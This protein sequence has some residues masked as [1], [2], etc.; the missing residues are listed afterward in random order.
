MKWADVKSCVS[1]CS[2]STQRA[3]EVA[4]RGT[5]EISV[6]VSHRDQKY[7]AVFSAYLGQGH[8]A[9]VEIT[10]DHKHSFSIVSKG[11]QMPGFNGRS[12]EEIGR[13]F[14][15]GVRKHHMKG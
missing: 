3:F 13:A 4:K 12:L 2:H 10:R 14:I 1:H 15:R 6:E 7:K 5:E 11:E 8:A 9:S